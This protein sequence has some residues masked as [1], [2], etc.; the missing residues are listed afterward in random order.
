MMRLLVMFFNK[1]YSF[2]GVFFLYVL[3]PCSVRYT[4]NLNSL[5]ILRRL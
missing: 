3:T 2:Y 5:I 4:N 1:A